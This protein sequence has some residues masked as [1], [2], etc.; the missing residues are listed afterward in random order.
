MCCLPLLW[1]QSGP[2]GRLSSG[3]TCAAGPGVSG[4][5]ADRVS[6][7]PRA[8]RGARCLRPPDLLPPPLPLSVQGC[9]GEH[10]A[11]PHTGPRG[12]EE[13]LASDCRTA[14]VLGLGPG[15]G[16]AGVP[17]SQPHQGLAPGAL[18][19]E[20]TLITLHCWAAGSAVGDPPSVPAGQSGRLALF[21]DGRPA[22]TCQ[23]GSGQ[24]RRPGHGCL[25]LGPAGPSPGR[26]LMASRS[27]AGRAGRVGRAHAADCIAV[28]MGP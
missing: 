20:R 9:L 22:S 14:G 26:Q 27:V 2:D 17:D 18:P 8:L 15:L 13:A 11:P 23:L 3:G 5:R 28:K 7:Q 10:L 19:Q 4:R 25:W 12:P 16:R 24:E 21:L 1:R 6:L